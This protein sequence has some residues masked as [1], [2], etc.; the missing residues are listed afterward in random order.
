MSEIRKLM[1]IG[2]HAPT[3]EALPDAL[4]ATICVV[5]AKDFI[6]S[7]DQC[8]EPAGDAGDA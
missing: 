8:R 5:A 7:V 6:D 1:D 2:E 3:L 4:D